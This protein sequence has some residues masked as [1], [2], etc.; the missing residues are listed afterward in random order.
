MW[1][2]PSELKS[3]NNSKVSLSDGL[4]VRNKV[5][6]IYEKL[7]C[8]RSHMWIHSVRSRLPLIYILYLELIITPH[9]KIEEA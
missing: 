8:L 4:H 1:G 2:D 7:V 5:T 6:L 9:Q 3:E